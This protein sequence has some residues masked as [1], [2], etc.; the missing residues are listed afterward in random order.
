[1]LSKQPVVTICL[2]WLTLAWLVP[3]NDLQAQFKRGALFYTSQ[4]GANLGETIRR[5]DE[6]QDG[7]YDF[8]VSAPGAS[9]GSNRNAG[10]VYLYHSPV[11]QDT[12]QLNETHVIL[13]GDGVDQEVGRRF[14]LGNFN[15]DQYIDIAVSNPEF[16]SDGSGV[17]KV[18]FG[19]F[20]QGQP[21][22]F[23][24]ADITISSSHPSAF[25]GISLSTVPDWNNDGRDEL[26]VGANE[27]D[28][29]SSWGGAVYL[30]NDL[31]SS[32][33]YSSEDRDAIF[34]GTDSNGRMGTSVTSFDDLNGNGEADIAI[35][36]H[37]NSSD[38]LLSGAVFIYNGPFDEQYYED[39]D[40]D[41]T[42]YGRDSTAFW[43]RRVFNT[44]DLNNDGMD[45]MAI[46]SQEENMVAYFQGR[47]VWASEITVGKPAETDGA[48]HT[49]FSRLSNNRKTGT[50]LDFRGDYDLDQ[51]RDPLIG[52]PGTHNQFERGAVGLFTQTG[53][54]VENLGY[55]PNLEAKFGRQVE[56]M[57]DIYTDP[58]DSLYVGN[59]LTVL[60]IDDVLIGAP[61]TVVERDG[62]SI[63]S[64][65][66]MLYTGRIKRP[67]TSLSFSPGPNIELNDT[68][69]VRAGY[70]PGSKPIVRSWLVF[71]R[72]TTYLHKEENNQNPFYKNIIRD[73]AA[74]YEVELFVQDSLGFVSQKRREVNF[75]AKPMPFNL[76]SD[77][78]SDTLRIVGDPAQ[79]TSFNFESTVDTNGYDIRYRLVLSL[80]DTV[81]EV[82]SGDL[83]RFSFQRNIPLELDYV[84]LN[85]FLTDKGISKNEPSKI[86]W[87]VQAYNGVFST[88]ASK[89][90]LRPMYVERQ[91]LDPYFQLWPNEEPM[92][93]EGRSNQTYRFEWSNLETEN[94][95][96]T[97]QYNF[98]LMEEPDAI[99]NPI[100]KKRTANNGF[101]N[102]YQLSFADADSL[103]DAYNLKEDAKN[104][105][106]SLH[107]S[108][109][110]IVDGQ[111]TWYPNNESLETGIAFENIVYVGIDDSDDQRPRQFKV[112]GN[113][114][115][116]FNPATRVK[117]ALPEAERV[118]LTVYNM[119]G[120]R[121][122]QWSSNGNISAGVH[123]HRV[124]A[125]AWS[126]GIYIYRLQAGKHRESGKMTLIK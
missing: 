94:P 100:F 39:Q 64:G 36:S 17:V 87:G 99:D 37:R 73:S 111:T 68:I 117:Y 41:V 18:F 113:Y 1:M 5:H 88:M 52:A 57:G 82:P 62:Q 67:T 42:I 78:S 86:F 51:K 116:P 118:R 46:T 50:D 98:M 20:I 10:K 40:A 106:I 120:Q 121:V 91:G 104:D 4:N 101:Q 11:P 15:G 19:P 9:V 108:V 110:A 28:F 2:L 71:G 63:S 76:L 12:I 105:T 13:E 114:P 83:Q 126:S 74:T 22:S 3:L 38:K 61:G 26:L 95:N 49:L 43:G 47:D 25:F 84:S 44:G 56:A 75:A 81:T 29:A 34:A 85:N 14:E 103:L 112:Y 48:D 27:S 21:R 6:N 125:E 7:L 119:L 23:S 72:D 109:E 59:E 33:D 79:T 115:N 69:R 97:V 96:S 89:G 107:F 53:I 80:A 58:D 8:F 66:V 122:Y 93:I 70:N 35:G 102:S 55:G 32:S 77:K 60:N 92:V 45:D 24:N 16:Y 30:F 31:G 123:H 90:Q 124:D 65:A 54:P